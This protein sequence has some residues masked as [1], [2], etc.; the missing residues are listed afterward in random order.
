MSW[1]WRVNNYILWNCLG[2]CDYKKELIQ[3]NLR[4]LRKY[5]RSVLKKCI[6]E[7]L[8]RVACFVAMPDAHNLATVL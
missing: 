1:K 2:T 8:H 4:V 7:D 6:H 5:R 3:I